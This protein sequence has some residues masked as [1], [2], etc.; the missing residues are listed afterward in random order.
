[1]L[2]IWDD[3]DEELGNENKFMGPFDDLDEVN[4]LPFC[5]ELLNNLK[6]CMRFKENWF[7]KYF[8]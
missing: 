8:S 6:N 1:M 3:S 2:A 5:D 4:E 7:K